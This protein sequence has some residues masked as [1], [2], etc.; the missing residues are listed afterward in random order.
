M[1]CVG[2]LLRKREGFWVH[3]MRGVSF[4]GHVRGVLVHEMRGVSFADT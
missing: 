4:A 2:C 3:E 1:K